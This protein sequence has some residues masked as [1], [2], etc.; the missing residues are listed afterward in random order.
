MPT[1]CDDSSCTACS[2]YDALGPRSRAAIDNLVQE[3]EAHV[4]VVTASLLLADAR[5]TEETFQ[6]LNQE[7]AF[8]RLVELIRTP[9]QDDEEGLHRLLMELLYEM[10]RIQKISLEDLSTSL[11]IRNPLPTSQTNIRR[12]AVSRTTL[13]EV[14]LI[15][16]SRF[17]ATS[18]TRTTIL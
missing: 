5:T 15:S 11:A 1:T 12:Q 4:Q 13:Y 9:K 3:E 16:S 17:R 2:R 14:C 8:P 7:G 10:S 18:V 6:L